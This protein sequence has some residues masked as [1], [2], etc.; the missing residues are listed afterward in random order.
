MTQSHLKISPV[1]KKKS[2]V[3]IGVTEC[4]VLGF[5]KHRGNKIYLH[6]TYS[7]IQ[8]KILIVFP[9]LFSLSPMNNS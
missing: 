2:I 1:K 9:R 5:A 6:I 3:L 8:A 7:T 4:K